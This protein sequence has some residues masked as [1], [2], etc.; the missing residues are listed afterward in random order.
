MSAAKV[1]KNAWRA[2]LEHY[3]VS[4]HRLRLTG[5]IGLMCDCSCHL[6]MQN[7]FQVSQQTIQ[8]TQIKLS[9]WEQTWWLPLSLCVQLGNYRGNCDKVH[10]HVHEQ[11]VSTRKQPN[12]VSW[13][14]RWRIKTPTKLEHL[15]C[16]NILSSDKYRR[17]L[18]NNARRW[19]W[20][21]NAL[22]PQLLGA[23]KQTYT[24][25]LL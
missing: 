23:N 4:L 9:C 17:E 21:A 12:N 19:G 20:K 15:C 13:S 2:S 8:E 3:P 14:I 16:L 25:R 24:F 11:S 5:M 10:I 18:R 7:K 6:T 22:R 1:C